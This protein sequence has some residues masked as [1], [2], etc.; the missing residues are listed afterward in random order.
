MIRAF[1]LAYAAICY[2]I[3]FA[4]FLYLI[5]FVGNLPIVDPTVD[6]AREA[7]PGQAVLIDIVLIALFGIQHSA[8]A[9]PGFKAAWT[10]IVPAP[11]ERSTYVLLAS[12]ALVLLMLFW[13]E[14]TAPVW[15]VTNPVGAAVLWAFFGLGLWTGVQKGPR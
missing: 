2:A 9:R 6:F 4:T 1:Y 14:L 5:A 12:L 7:P 10:R 8:M 3:F 11:I 15:T 13:H